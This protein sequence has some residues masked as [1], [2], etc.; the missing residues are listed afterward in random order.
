VRLPKE[1][2]ESLDI[3]SRIHRTPVSTIIE[4]LVRTWAEENRAAIDRAREA[5]APASRE[6]AGGK[7]EKRPARRR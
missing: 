3:Y 7:T 4:D 2:D 6:A 5:F 1:L